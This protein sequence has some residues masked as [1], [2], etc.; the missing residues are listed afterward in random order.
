MGQLPGAPRPSRSAWRGQTLARSDGEQTRSGTP[1]TSG[2][3]AARPPSRPQP[4]PDPAPA[5]F[6][7]HPQ[8]RPRPF[9]L[10]PRP[11][12]PNRESPLPA[13]LQPLPSPARGPTFKIKLA[14]LYFPLHLYS[15]FCAPSHYAPPTESSRSDPIQVNNPVGSALPTPRKHRSILRP[16]QGHPWLL[17]VVRHSPSLGPSS[18][19][20]HRCPRN[21]EGLE[22][23]GWGSSL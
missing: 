6:R 23:G 3:P 21:R 17:V 2:P 10:R 11:D 8:P 20:R 18:A 15:L 12:H 22:S 13:P 7:P 1:Q 19:P 14:S 9:R 4:P 16:L 5:P